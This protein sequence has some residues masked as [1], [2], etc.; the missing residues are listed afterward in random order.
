MID[1]TLK[2][3]VFATGKN[4]LVLRIENIRDLFDNYFYVP[5]TT[6]YVKVDCLASLL[7]S[8]ANSG[9]LPQ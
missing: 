8:L 4:T 3:E 6:Q 5:P 7:Y 2:Y 9:A 1:S